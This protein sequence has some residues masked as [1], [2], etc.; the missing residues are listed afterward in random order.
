[1]TQAG[2]QDETV[3]FVGRRFRVEG[4]TS[5]NADGSAR[6]KEIVRHPG[7]VVILPLVDDH[8]VCL[9]RNYRVAVDQTLIELPAGTLEEGEEPLAAASRE[10]T[11]ETGY[12]AEHLEPLLAVH[13]SPGILDEQMR[14]FVATGL[15]AGGASR[16]P[17]E[18]IENLVLPWN[19]ALRL[20][21]Q[22]AIQDAKTIIALL[23]YDRFCRRRPP[24]ES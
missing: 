4:L 14:L 22:K 5:S 11:E 10:L 21:E 18:Q 20:V 17:D 3:L 13:P 19:E 1:M 7:S 9:I 23:Y 2:N 6:R 12:R 16:E 24:D 8:H 15:T